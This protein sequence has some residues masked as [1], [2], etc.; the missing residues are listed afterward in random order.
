[1]GLGTSLVAVAWLAQATTGAAPQPPALRLGNT[2][3][4]VE[5]A[6]E[7][8]LDPDRDDFS[9]VVNAVVDVREPVHLFWISA[10]SNLS[11][12]SADL[13]SNGQHFKAHVIPA[14]KDFVGFD[15]ESALP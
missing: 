5:Y 7:L 10:A 12:A 2:V 11:V 1:M 3:V 13:E 14:G 15:F 4:P 8:R 9:G 6:L